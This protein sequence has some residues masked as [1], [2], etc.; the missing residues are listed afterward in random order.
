MENPNSDIYLTAKKIWGAVVQSDTSNPLEIKQQ[1]ELHKRLLNVFQVGRHYYM[2]F[3]VYRSELE[4]ISEGMTDV[5]GYEPDEINAMLFLERIHPED[6]P[7]F[8]AFENRTTDFLQQLPYDKRGKYKYQ[9]DYRIKAKSGTYLRILHQILPI[10]YDENN[11]Y[12]SL[13]LHTDISHIK[14]DGYPC[15]SI[16]GLDGESSYYNLQGS[17]PIGDKSYDLFTPRER[18]IVNCIVEGKSSKDIAQELFISM[19][20]VNAH[21]KNILKKAD[22]KTPLELVRK[23]IKEGWV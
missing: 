3:N 17:T 19:H 13:V 15:L 12:R 11:F 10:E 16:I 14:P 21:R 1:L 22:A 23:V 20:T 8:L 7:Y 9:H 6:K 18:Q 5:L 4:F 2:I